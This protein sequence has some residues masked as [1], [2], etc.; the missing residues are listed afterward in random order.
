MCSSSPKIEELP[1]QSLPTLSQPRVQQ[2]RNGG[3]VATAL[4]ADSDQR[5]L[6]ISNSCLTA[7]HIM[8]ALLIQLICAHHIV[9]LPLDAVL[10]Y[11]RL[12]HARRPSACARQGALAHCPCRHTRS[13]NETGRWPQAHKTASSR[14]PANEVTADNRSVCAVQE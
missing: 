4:R 10:A 9:G 14:T 12:I 2:L 13:Q 8:S 11:C 1:P 6:G 5:R 7:M 3:R